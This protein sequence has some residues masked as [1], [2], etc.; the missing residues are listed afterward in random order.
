MNT[1]RLLLPALL[2]CAFF[3]FCFAQKQVT[4]KVVDSATGEPLGGVSVVADKKKSGV[5]TAADGSFTLPVD[6]KTAVIILSSVGYASQTFA[7]SSLPPVIRLARAAAALDEVVVIGYGT[8]RRSN[9]T[10]AVSRYSNQRMDEQPVSRIDQALQGKI[11]GVQVQNL[12]SEAGS[13]PRIRVRGLSSMNA[14]ASPLVV[15][16]G[17]PVQDGLN[18]VNP[19]DVASVDVLKDASSAAIYGSRGASGVILITTKSGR[20]DRTRYNVKYSTGVKNDYKRYHMLTFSEYANLLFYEAGLRAKD[21]SVPAAQQNLINANERAAYVIENTIAG[22]PTDWQS[23]ALRNATVQ[24]LQLNVSG[25]NRALKYYIGGGYQKDPGLMYHS[26]YNKYNLRTKLE[27]Q[28]SNRV[29]L[30]LNTNPSYIQRERPSVNYI[31]FVRFY[32]FLPVYHTAATATY[33][34]STGGNVRV[35]DFVQANDFNAK[36]YSGSM[37]DGS[38]WTS[39]AAPVTPFSTSNNTPKS[40][41]ETRAIKSNEYRMLSSADLTVNILPG[42]DFKTL[43]SA[44]VS[45]TSALDFA[46]RNSNRQGDL[47]RGQYNDRRFVDLLWENTLNYTRRFG[48]HDLTA[49][50][51]FTSQK[52][53]IRDQQ[54]VGLDYPSDNI[55]TLNTALTKDQAAT[56]DSLTQIGL[57]SVLGRIQYAFK[58]KYLLSVSLR[59][60]E[61]SFFAPGHKWGYFPAAS[62]G[63]VA[64]QE[65]FLKNVAWLSNLKLRGSYGVSGNNRITEVGSAGASPYIDLLYAANYPLGS[66]NSVAQGFAPSGFILANPNLTWE[67]TFQYNGGIDLSLFHNLLSLSIDVYQSRTEKLLL[68]QTTQLFAGVSKYWNNIGQ[69]QNRGAEAELTANPVRGKDFRWTVSG[70]IARNRNKLLSFGQESRV[71]NLGE[72]N[73]VYLNGVGFPAIQ[74]YAYKTDGVWLSQQQI[75]DAKAKGLTSNLTNLFVA[76]GLKLADVNGDNVID[77]N[78][79]VAGGSP[80]PD[81][82]Y[83]LTNAL[84]YKG[85]DVSFTFQGSHGGKLINGDPNYN[86][87]R[88]INRNYL[89]NRWISPAYPGDG[90]TPY[91]VN[92]FNWMLTDYVI[93]DASYLALREAIVG[94]T[95]PAKLTNRLKLTG[96]RLYLS[97]QN[98]WYGFAKGY[99]GINPEARFNTGPYLSPLIDGY[100]RGS[101]PLPQTLLFGVDVN[102]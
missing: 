49:V 51:G 79:R 17:H 80:Y 102:F 20:T 78:D 73:E 54:A 95:F 4:G 22:G 96:A 99:R 37:P 61:S 35:G 101:F 43:A 83:G 57:N 45:Y 34:N 12:S 91:N 42:L 97:A 33:V 21:P 68:Q 70:N 47:S 62:V 60:D 81:F 66:G 32:S 19:A 58:S 93:E 39:G 28:L 16:D 9:V 44:Y 24:N 23:Q 40:V 76:G 10:G 27:A 41:M 75:D 82:T 25:G 89:E 18:F 26:D 50:M 48:D 5:S 63:W 55:S 15:I 100:Q 90:K 14:G 84:T 2:Q 69:L 88:R 77:A 98:L 94:Y 31:D 56:W 67:R 3:T 46:K 72:R 1:G 7:P 13:D 6:N 64:T 85:I 38:F 92:G 53:R 29:K 74:Y 8:Q 86:E 87:T 59:G 30:T 36:T 52:T 11:A 71:L 65:K